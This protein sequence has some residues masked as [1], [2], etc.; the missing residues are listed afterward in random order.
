M[1]KSL[2]D[3]QEENHF[4][5]IKLDQFNNSLIVARAQCWSSHGQLS[6]C[7]I[8]R[9][10]SFKAVSRVKSQF[11]QLGKGESTEGTPSSTI[12]SSTM[13]WTIWFFSRQGTQSYLALEG[14]RHGFS[15]NYK[16][17]YWDVCIRR[18]SRP[19]AAP[20]LSKREAGSYPYRT[21]VTQP[22]SLRLLPRPPKLWITA[23]PAHSLTA[24]HYPRLPSA[25]SRTL[26]GFSPLATA[27]RGAGGPLGWASLST[28]AQNLGCCVPPSVRETRPVQAKLL[29][30]WGEGENWGQWNGGEQ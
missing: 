19:G 5:S 29:H 1:L 27:R 26:H 11:G 10:K 3:L 22:K 2:P 8:F 13:S 17:L 16:S 21:S 6:G 18:S 30:E 12:V 7:R 24:W 28:S 23:P 20:H 14:T 15:C 25:F 9:H 4:F